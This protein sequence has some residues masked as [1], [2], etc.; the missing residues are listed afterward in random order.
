MHTCA[1][2]TLLRS[3]GGIICAGHTN[4][5]N[6]DNI[7]NI[8]IFRHSMNIGKIDEKLF[9]FGISI[10]RYSDIGFVDFALVTVR[11]I[12]P[13]RLHCT[14]IIDRVKGRVLYIR[15]STVKSHLALPDVRIIMCTIDFD[16]LWR[17]C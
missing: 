1:V 10:F 17:R 8:D 7:D 13:Y 6:I 16:S 9:N 15:S 2:R 3:C 4:M 14:C 5:G 12:S 11:E